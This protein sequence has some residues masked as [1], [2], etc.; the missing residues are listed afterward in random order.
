MAEPELNSDYE[1]DEDPVWQSYI[2]PHKGWY[3][4]VSIVWKLN[5]ENINCLLN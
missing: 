1:Y 3:N 5:N 2:D 4:K